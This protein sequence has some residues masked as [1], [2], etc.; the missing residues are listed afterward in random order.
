MQIVSCSKTTYLQGWDLNFRPKFE[1][2][3]SQSLDQHTAQCLYKLFLILL[4]YL[5]IMLLSF[6]NGSLIVFPYLFLFI[7][8]TLFSPKYLFSS[9]KLFTIN[10][11]P[12][13]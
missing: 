13:Y 11:F 10:I 3:T 8:I 7:Y 2:T 6:V 4:K 5:I 12:S 9:I 1:K